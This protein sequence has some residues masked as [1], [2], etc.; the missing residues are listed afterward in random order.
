MTIPWN[1]NWGGKGKQRFLNIAERFLNLRQFLNTANGM[2]CNQSLNGCT[3]EIVN[4]PLTQKLL[5]LRGL[6]N[7]QNVFI[8][9]DSGA[10]KNFMSYTFV[11]NNKITLDTR[12]KDIIRLANGQK[13]TGEG[14]AKSLR[15]HIGPYTARSDFSVATLTQGY[16]L[17]LGKPWLT[18]INPSINWQKN[19]VKIR[20]KGGDLV[21]KGLRNSHDKQTYRIEVNEVKMHG[22]EATT[23]SKDGTRRKATQISRHEQDDSGIKKKKPKE[24]LR[25]SKVLTKTAKEEVS[26]FQTGA[27]QT[28]NV[29]AQEVPVA[30][31]Q[32]KRQK[33]ARRSKKGT[34]GNLGNILE[35]SSCQLKRY[36]RK[37]QPIFLGV[38]TPA[39]E[40][41]VL[42]SSS[43]NP[44]IKTV[45]VQG[46]EEKIRLQRLLK[47]FHDVFP[48]ELPEGLPPKRQ[49][50]HKID[51]QPGSQP[52]HRS[53]YRMS[54]KEMEELK[55]QIDRFLK[56][57]HIRPSISPYG[58]PVLFAPKKDGGL[59]F[60]IDYR[61]LNKNTIKNRYPL[62]K[63]DELLDQLAGARVF[64]KIDLRSGYHQIRV[65]PEDIHK[66]AFRTRYGH[67][68]FTVVPFGLCNAPATFMRLMNSIMHPYL[69]K[70]VV[71]FLDDILIYSKDLKEHEDHLRLVLKQLRKHQLYG[72]VSKCEFFKKQLEY[73]G[74]DVSS[75]GI[76][77]SPAKIE[78]IKTW[79]TPQTVRQVR[80]F[81]G[82]ANFYRKFIKGFSEIAKPLTEL[83]KK[84]IP[85][86]WGNEQEM[87]MTKL[88][89]ALCTAPV[90][91]LPDLA[92]PFVVH[93]DA[94]SFA[95]GGVLQQDSGKGLQPI[96]YESRKLNSTERRYSAYE[97]ELLA[98]L[99][100]CNTWR[101]YLCGKH[102]TIRTDHHSLRYIFSQQ[103]FSGRIFKWME[104]LQQYDFTV[105]HIP[106][107][108]NLVADALSRRDE[109]ISK[110]PTRNTEGR[111]QCS[112]I[113]HL[114]DADA[115]RNQIKYGYLRDDLFRE[116]KALL[117]PSGDKTIV[118]KFKREFKLEGDLM[119]TRKEGDDQS[120]WQVYIPSSKTVK[121]KI[122][123]E[124]HD[125]ESAGHLGYQKT[126]Q[127]VNRGFWWH[128]ITE[129]IKD[130]VFSCQKC[131]E[132][133]ASKQTPS[134]LLQPLPIPTG[135]WRDISM[136]FITELPKSSRGNDAIMTV[137]DRATKMTHFIATKTDISAPE[138]AELFRDHVW[139]THGVPRSIVSDRDTR[140]VSIFWRSLMK[141]VGTKLRF[142]TAYHPQ[143]DGQSEKMNDVVEQILRTY[144]V[145]KPEDWDRRL[146][147]A[148]YAINNS[149]N[150]STGYSP[151]YLNYGYNPDSPL[152]IIT[153][154][155]E[156]KNQS[157]KD[158]TS[159]LEEDFE[160]AMQNL[161]EAQHRQKKYADQHR[162]PEEFKE[163]DKVMLST[164][165]GK[166]AFL[167]G[168]GIQ[169]DPKFR[170]KFVGPFKIERKVS[171]TAYVL[172]LPQTWSAHPVFHVS[173][174][175][176][177]QGG[178]RVRTTQPTT[179]QRAVK[180]SE[181]IYEV[182]RILDTRMFRGKRQY[183]VHWKGYQYYDATWE[184]E[185]HLQGSR[186]L[187]QDFWQRH[188]GQAKEASRRTRPK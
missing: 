153:G 15:F 18:T 70:F 50:D 47:E 61:A 179:H 83:T 17:I 113:T 37:G 140:F 186:M 103:K 67:Y 46:A 21:L 106:G 76:K 137:V 121:Q 81:V 178:S 12:V 151:F 157:V 88:K 9:I 62:P 142:S 112:G 108:K 174:L 171:K 180:P 136:D 117:R 3:D 163:G 99:H 115:L 128:G 169:P 129:D 39:N 176:A 120:S 36:A 64:T 143:T 42:A 10:S 2:N 72:K 104:Q 80:S 124:L 164:G 185:E 65:V 85:F 59:R 122:L 150:I 111:Q 109:E 98:V 1:Q 172:K 158:W 13:I 35:I 133:K 27:A 16:D 165:K 95:L 6:V 135:K 77:V 188:Q 146:A 97:R 30:N 8:M 154:A 93:T 49:V 162:K 147:A 25:V 114:R 20:S 60:C 107:W 55:K 102:F 170:Q 166:R 40:G 132:M 24:Q 144:T 4:T 5:I 78:A 160:D 11:Q 119:Y 118:T 86:E 32:K 73:L 148:E 45:K 43:V 74:H 26:R 123:E 145:Y 141:L 127:A 156:E 57:G 116:L 87:A 31:S 149:V 29:H 125:S 105:E 130:Y 92:R 91:L 131:Q 168:P 33:R 22:N 71:V 7:D 126:V 23:I 173:R 182:Q 48:V 56:L 177:W 134:G 68:E 94:S 152:D 155:R 51:L 84:D 82:L 100:S 161:E 183:L 139:K 69:D 53:P 75:E 101:H 79:P 58:A 181:D 44:N 167:T 90:L 19:E 159:Q 28:S 89:R 63:I 38:M 14:T 110:R 34:D 184:P 41:V 175:K 54:P 96:A 138:V 187:V 66:T 52:Q